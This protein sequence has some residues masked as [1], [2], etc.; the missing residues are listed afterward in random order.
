MPHAFFKQDAPNRVQR[1]QADPIIVLCHFIRQPPFAP[2]W[3]GLVHI[4]H[5][6]SDFFRF[7]ACA[8]RRTPSLKCF[9]ACIA[10][11]F[12][13]GQPVIKR[14]AANMRGATRYCD[15]LGLLPG[16]KKQFPRI[17]PLG[18]GKTASSL[19][20]QISQWWNGLITGNS[21]M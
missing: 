8:W 2:V 5:F 7:S 11:F 19:R 17:F 20:D 13:L 15:A 10:F 9:Q 6:G 16:L 1:N 3:M 18:W 21:A 14:R 12:E 4:Y